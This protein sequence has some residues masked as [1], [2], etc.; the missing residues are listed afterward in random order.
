[1]SSQPVAPGLSPKAA[2]GMRRK[3]GGQL[4]PPSRDCGPF[5]PGHFVHP[6][7]LTAAE[8]DQLAEA[9]FWLDRP[10]DSVDARR[11]A[12]AAH[13][14]EGSVTGAARVAWQLF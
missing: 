4:V 11:D 5:L 1:M 14:V 8:G 2:A 3:G 10:A 9:L 13:L 6:P 7:E 12:Y